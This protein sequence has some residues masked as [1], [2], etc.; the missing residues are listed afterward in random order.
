MPE[1]YRNA[2]IFVA[3]SKPTATWEEQYNT[4]LLEAQSSGLPIV[5]TDS[6]GIPENVGSAA[7]I[8]LPGDV[9]G[10]TSAIKQYVLSAG[11]R[12][13]FTL[14]ARKRAL[15]KH[16]IHIGASKLSALYDELIS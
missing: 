14:K 16:D 15:F 3:P 5:T 13:E 4:A 6:G 7:V 11:K 12:R 1:V 2:E 9:A 10:L 8:V